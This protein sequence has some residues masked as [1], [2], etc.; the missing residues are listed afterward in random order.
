MIDALGPKT[1]ILNLR[2]HHDGKL[3]SFTSSANLSKKT[4]Y[5]MEIV[6]IK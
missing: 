5:N 2:V 4:S 6:L 3:A 1:N